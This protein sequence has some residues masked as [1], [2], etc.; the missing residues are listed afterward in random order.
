MRLLV[1]DFGIGKAVLAAATQGAES[2]TQIGVTVGTPAYMSPEQAAGDTIDG[3]SDLFALGCMLYEML[4]GEQ[5]FT[6]PT[7][8]ATIAKRF[9][10]SPP[11]DV[12]QA[13]RRVTRERRQLSVPDPRSAR[14]CAQCRRGWQQDLCEHRDVSFRERRGALHRPR[15]RDRAQCGASPRRTKEE[16]AW[17]RASGR[18]ANIASAAARSLPHG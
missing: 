15:A 7:I 6:G 3:R 4:T 10:H 16:R 14:R 2:L 17:R 8:Q 18:L 12:D 1:A 5:P 13:R 9:H 11:H